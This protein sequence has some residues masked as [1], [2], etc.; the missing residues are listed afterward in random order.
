MRRNKLNLIVFISLLLAGGMAFTGCA[1]KRLDTAEMEGSKNIIGRVDVVEAEAATDIVI[2]GSNPANYTSFKLTD[3]LR[4]VIDI[5]DADISEVAG[6]IPVNNGTIKDI[7]IS[8]Y[9]EGEVSVARLELALDKMT[10][11]G[12]EKDNNKLIVSLATTAAEGSKKVAEEPLEVAD[13]KTEGVGTIPSVDVEEMQ[14]KAKYLAD[15]SVDKRDGRIVLTARGEGYIG[16]YNSFRMKRPSR[17]VIDLLGLTNLYKKNR[18]DVNS[19]MLKRIRIGQHKDKVRLVLD[20]PEGAPVD[21]AVSKGERALF[22]VLGKDVEGVRTFEPEKFVAEGGGEEKTRAA[23]TVARD[24]KHK[25]IQITA[26]NFKQLP[27]VSRVTISAT[28][29]MEYNVKALG[30]DKVAIDIHGATIP[31]NLQRSL[32]T[33]EFNSPVTLISSYQLRKAP[34]SLVRI[35]IDLRGK[36]AYQIGKGGGEFYIDF[37]RGTYAEE[38]GEEVVAEAEMPPRI[39]ETAAMEIAVEGT[40]TEREAVRPPAVAKEAAKEERP[41]FEVETGPVYTGQKVSLDYKDA[42][43]GNIL[44]LFAEVSGLNIIA[45][46]D[47]KGTVTVKLD[48]VPW[49]QALDIVLQA[50]DLGMSRIGNVIRIAPAAKLKS[51]EEARK[52]EEEA[53]LAAKKAM[54]K[55][56]DLVVDIVPVNYATA[57]DMS[58]KI[59]DVLTERGKVTVDERTNVLIIKDVADS[60]KAARKL[61]KTLDTATP[62]VLIEAR[63]VEIDT[64]YTRDL[65]IQWGAGYTADAS[66]GNPLGYRFPNSMKIGLGGGGGFALNPPSIG[67]NPGGGTGTNTESGAG[68]AIGFNF[69]SIDNTLSLDLKL[70]ALETKGVSKIIS[71]PRIVT[72][73]NKEAVIQQGF[74]I[75]FETTSADGTQTEFIDANLNLT[76]TPHITTDKSVILQL[77]AAKNEPDFARTG[78]GGAPSISKKEANTEVLIK[79]GDTTVIGGIITQKE[80]KSETGIPFL[81]KIPLIGWLFKSR[82][83]T[84]DKAELLIFITPRIVTKDIQ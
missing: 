53:E 13:E 23:K 83:K 74:S 68:A 81:S 40:R 65:G 37:E 25:D 57:S 35:V 4:V 2:E 44:R 80:G 21:Y 5:S 27:K 26:V 52:R 51:E 75:P 64:N 45:T 16:D 6:V 49:D 62:Q 28:E 72:M 31:K 50:K 24:K 39:V 46:E 36:T 32:D 8:Q 20:I 73:D 47:V 58:A 66:T 54:E 82:S 79:D 18:V 63:I 41:R 48:D 76:V 67:A 12:I 84:D 70:S 9:D 17:I 71:R 22:V 61:V 11:Y 34:D 33:S 19:P 69:G 43:I 42:D 29:S 59:A 15:L 77:K 10:E 30:E 14:K 1:P 38:V 78:A 3:P 55:L 60:V 7:Q 56:E